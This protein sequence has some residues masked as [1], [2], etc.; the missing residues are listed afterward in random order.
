VLEEQQGSLKV[1]NHHRGE[2]TT[3]VKRR[4][5]SPLAPVL[6]EGY[7]KVT[8]EA[9]CDQAMTGDYAVAGMPPANFRTPR[10]KREKR[11]PVRFRQ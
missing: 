4:E 1:E 8:D 6:S 5:S 3:D 9:Q 7:A 11:V 10:P 2:I